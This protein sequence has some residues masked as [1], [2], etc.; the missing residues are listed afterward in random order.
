SSAAYTGWLRAHH[1][2]R[3]RHPRIQNHRL[4]PPNQRRLSRLRPI[5]THQRSHRHPHQSPP[6]HRQN[7]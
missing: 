3:H 2:R 4:T 7:G 6:I 1:P 5:P